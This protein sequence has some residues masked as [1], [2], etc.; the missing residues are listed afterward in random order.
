MSN[1]GIFRCVADG[2][3][4]I[5]EGVDAVELYEYARPN[6]I[7]AVIWR[8]NPDMTDTQI[9]AIAEISEFSAEGLFV[10][11]SMNVPMVQEHLTHPLGEQAQRWGKFWHE[12]GLH[13]RL[14][15]HFPDETAP[16]LT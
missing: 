11:W 16:P 2:S 9:A 4:Q 7:M 8:E 3:E 12:Y 13:K 5:F 15:A 6:G 14:P 10:G 1:A